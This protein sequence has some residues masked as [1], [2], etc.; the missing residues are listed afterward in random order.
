[1]SDRLAEVLDALARA[2]H[3]QA[4]VYTKRGRSRRL[5]L[6]ERNA[7]A[8]TT[9][10][11]GWA[12]RAGTAQGSFFLASSGAPAPD[13]S[14]PEPRGAPLRLPEPATPAEGRPPADLEAPL[15]AESEARALLEAIGRELASE[16]PGARLHQA[17]LEE[18]TSESILRSS[19]GVHAAWRS[20][21]ALLR[22]DALAAGSRRAR[23][24]VE[25]AERLAAGF[26]P[27][28]LARRLADRLHV[29]Q[30]GA[31][32][33]RDRGEFLL[34]PPVG[35]KL[36]LGLL[37]ALVGA[38]A[39]ARLPAPTTRGARAAAE[40]LTLVDDGRLP[41]GV[42]AAPVDGEGSPTREIVLIGQGEVRQ[43][44]LPWWAARPPQT[45]S[46]GCVRR[47]SYRDVPAVGPSHLYVR[48][49]P[50][51]PVATLLASVSRGYYLLDATGAARFDFAADRLAVPVCG[52]TVQGGRARAPVRGAFLCGG[53]GAWLR[54]IQAVARDLAFLPLEGMLGAPSMLVTGLELRSA[55]G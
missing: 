10:E 23:A 15:L 37:P 24:T 12:V 11:E 30:T 31:A 14:W 18:G 49:Q 32:P 21:G 39:T 20:R 9:V 47:A 13:T 52:F 1:M 43:P 17:S 36:L 19:R 25:V 42:L 45:R 8:T 16:L 50:D 28:A 35:A 34:A 27:S 55:P 41:G 7:L 53:I 26:S 38:G 4:E 6:G 29:Q 5:V 48:P 51:V 54:G 2:G 33:E 3:D 44:L 22:L 46:T 40:T